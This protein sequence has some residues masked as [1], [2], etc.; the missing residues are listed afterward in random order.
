[1]GKLM[2]EPTPHPYYHTT[3][4]DAYYNTMTGQKILDKFLDEHSF[5]IPREL[6]EKNWKPDVNKR[7]RVWWDST[8][9]ADPADPGYDYILYIEECSASSY[10]NEGVKLWKELIGKLSG[11]SNDQ[12]RKIIDFVDNL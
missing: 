11:K 8:N 1:M 9:P 5:H 10:V 3:C 12:M 6:E 2:E 7:Y 4:K